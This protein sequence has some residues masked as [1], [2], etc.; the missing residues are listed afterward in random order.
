MHVGGRS[1]GAAAVRRA[2]GHSEPAG[3]PRR[4]GIGG[5]DLWYSCIEGGIAVA[6]GRFFRGR[7]SRSMLVEAPSFGLSGRCARLQLATAPTR[8]APPSPPTTTPAAAGRR[9]Q[10]GLEIMQA[11]CG[12]QI[13]TIKYIAEPRSHCGSTRPTSRRYTGRS[14]VVEGLELP[15]SISICTAQPRWYV[16]WLMM[17]TS[18]SK[19]DMSPL[20]S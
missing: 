17:C 6:V 13:K 2:R 18:I 12:R 8:A 4:G 10:P 19:A 14:V 5:W 9:R 7:L 1:L 15:G 3:S 20:A 11:D 16:V